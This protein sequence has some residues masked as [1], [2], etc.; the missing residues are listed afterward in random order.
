MVRRRRAQEEAAREAVR[1][2]LMTPAQRATATAAIDAN[3]PAS[4]GPPGF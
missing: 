4:Q 3:F 2:S 1:R